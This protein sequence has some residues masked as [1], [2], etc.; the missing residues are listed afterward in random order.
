MGFWR[1]R[2]MIA[3]GSVEKT[4]S[5]ACFDAIY[6]QYSSI[7]QNQGRKHEKHTKIQ[8]L[9]VR[10]EMIDSDRKIEIVTGLMHSADDESSQFTRG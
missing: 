8:K 2:I 6:Y 9:E 4:S 10:S 3:L 1:V 5:Y 7:Y